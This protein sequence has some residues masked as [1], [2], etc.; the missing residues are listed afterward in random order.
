MTSFQPKAQ[1]I[2]QYLDDGVDIG[3]NVV[4]LQLLTLANGEVG[5]A[6]ERSFKGSRSAHSL[7]VGFGIQVFD[8][9]KEFY[10][11]SDFF[12][13]ELTDG[14]PHWYASYRRYFSGRGHDGPEG[15]Y[16]TLFYRNRNYNVDTGS[17]RFNDFCWGYGYQLYFSKGL[18][19][20][21][22]AMLG[23]RFYKYRDVEI[24]EDESLSGGDL[25]PAAQ[26]RFGYMF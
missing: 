19:I 17:L 3:F 9:N 1:G 20:D 7:E 22:N 14:G 6:Y 8:Y 21:V 11:S 26:I 4:K 13:P 10:I 23:F 18:I 2:D 25:I 16:T 24:S 12:V 15:S 5:M